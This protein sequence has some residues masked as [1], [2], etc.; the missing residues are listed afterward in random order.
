MERPEGHYWLKH[1]SGEWTV[2]L[3]EPD[4]M[5]ADKGCWWQI[6]DE[7]ALYDGDYLEVGAPIRGKVV[8]LEPDG[9]SEDGKRFTVTIRPDLDSA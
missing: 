7:Q 6:G 3:W 2:G 9:L 5:G 8:P 4:A 1:R